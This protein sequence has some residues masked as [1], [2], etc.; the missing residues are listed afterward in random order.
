[1][2]SYLSSTLC[3]HVQSPSKSRNPIEDCACMDGNIC[4]VFCVMVYYSITNLL[5]SLLLL[6]RPTYEKNKYINK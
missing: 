1:M 4:R 3:R 6:A 5:I 2:S